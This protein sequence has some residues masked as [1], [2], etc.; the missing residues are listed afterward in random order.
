MNDEFEEAERDWIAKVICRMAL[1]LDKEIM[2]LGL[3]VKIDWDSPKPL[4]V[5]EIPS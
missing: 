4:S 2:N 1:K 5:K 3:E